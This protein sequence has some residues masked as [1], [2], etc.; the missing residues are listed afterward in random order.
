MR[1]NDASVTSLLCTCFMVSGMQATE[2][3]NG[4]VDKKSYALNT[5]KGYVVF[6]N[7]LALSIA[8]SMYAIDL[9]CDCT[10]CAPT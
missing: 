1:R 10:I 3:Y 9:S 8:K 4:T 2:I 5:F 7:G 6:S